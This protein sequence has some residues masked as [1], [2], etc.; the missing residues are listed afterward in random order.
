MTLNVHSTMEINYD[1]LANMIETMEATGVFSL[2][3]VREVFGSVVDD[4][5]QAEIDGSQL[6]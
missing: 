2:N 3:A 1:A 4:A 6:S 5:I